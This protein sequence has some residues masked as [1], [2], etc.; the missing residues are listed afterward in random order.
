[1]NLKLVTWQDPLCSF[2]SRFPHGGEVQRR[3]LW[4]EVCTKHMQFFRT[5]SH[6]GQEVC[7]MFWQLKS[8]IVTVF[9]FG[10]GF[11]EQ[12]VDS[13]VTS[14][15]WLVGFRRISLSQKSF[16]PTRFIGEDQSH[17][18]FLIHGSSSLTSAGGD[19]FRKRTEG[20]KG[21]LT[22]RAASKTD[23]QGQIFF[24]HVWWDT[25]SAFLYQNYLVS[26]WRF[27]W[28][29][30]EGEVVQQTSEPK[31]SGMSCHRDWG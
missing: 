30:Q 17:V 11:S 19:F 31:S 9:S 10:L 23:P 2:S 1:M 16:F 21:A 25:V 12:L 15:F 29:I 7:D 8:A 22:L 20:R 24:G 4:K 18:E 14:R 5:N 6:Q 26:E 3:F 27:L 13:N 28:H